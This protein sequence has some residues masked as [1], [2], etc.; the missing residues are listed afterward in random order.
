MKTEDFDEAVATAMAT[1]PGWFSEVET[2]ATDEEVLS[3]ERLLGIALPQEYKHFAKKFGAGYFGQVN[4]TSLK[5]D[6][7]WYRADSL[8]QLL[9]H[10]NLYVLSDDETGGFYGFVLKADGCGSEVVYVHPDDGNDVEPVAQSFFDYIV[11]N[12]LPTP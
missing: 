8:V 10:G 3:V 11:G 6:S 1:R 7:E 5:A 12:G 9:E 2:P 4:I